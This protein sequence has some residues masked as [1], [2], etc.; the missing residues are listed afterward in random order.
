MSKLS[1]K[2]HGTSPS[3]FSTGLLVKQ[4][5][6]ELS[7]VDAE[8]DNSSESCQ[9]QRPEM[10]YST[11]HSFPTSW[12]CKQRKKSERESESCSFTGF[13]HSSLKGTK[14]FKLLKQTIS[15]TVFRLWAEK[16]HYSSVVKRLKWYIMCCQIKNNICFL[17]VFWERTCSLWSESCISETDLCVGSRTWHERLVFLFSE[18]SQ[19]WR[20]RRQSGR[21]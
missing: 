9:S 5:L 21:G 18:R 19:G 4:S 7:S 12:I 11:W 3:S 16:S 1:A 8:S 17:S 10:T 15:Y 20:V 2:E 13:H 6:P 14:L